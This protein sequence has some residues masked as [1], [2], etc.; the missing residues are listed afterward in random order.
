MAPPNEPLDQ[1]GQDGDGDERQHI[2]PAGRVAVV[3]HHDQVAQ[4][5]DGDDDGEVDAPGVDE[6]EGSHRT[7]K[8]LELFGL[9]DHHDRKRRPY[10]VVDAENYDQDVDDRVQ[11]T[12][13]EHRDDDGQVQSHGQRQDQAVEGH[14][15]GVHVGGPPVSSSIGTHQVGGVVR[16]DVAMTLQLR[17]V[18][19]T[20]DVVDGAAG[21]LRGRDHL[22]PSDGRD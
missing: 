20:A 3:P 6:Q 17:D 11:L 8:R 13:E 18:L 22:L 4:D 10:Q 7:L 9:L 5:G 19:Q 14:H 12:V 21:A 15:G 16:P 1:G 2:P